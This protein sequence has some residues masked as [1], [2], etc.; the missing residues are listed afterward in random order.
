MS[1]ARLSPGVDKAAQAADKA[2][3]KAA[4]VLD[5]EKYYPLNKLTVKKALS[6]TALS[7]AILLSFPVV[8]AETQP[9]K[10]GKTAPA[11]TMAA[12]AK[13]AS[14]MPK[15]D[16]FDAVKAMGEELQAAMGVAE[17]NPSVYLD[18]IVDFHYTD[19]TQAKLDKVFGPAGG[20]TI[21][22]APADAGMLHYQIA[23][24]ANSYTE[25]SGPQLTWTDLS[26]DLMLNKAGTTMSSRGSWSQFTVAGKD[27]TMVMKDMTVSS[28]QTRMGENI[29]LGKVEAGIASITAG[30]VTLSSL[31][32]SGGASAKG[33]LITAGYDGRIKTIEA[34]GKQVDDLHIAARLTN[35][36]AKTMEKFSRDFNGGMK[37]LSPE[38]K[39][40]AMKPI[41]KA[42]GKS[43]A[44]NGSAF[45]I[46]D[47]SLGFLANRASI[48]GKVSMGKTTD[49]DFSNFDAFGKK[50]IVRLNVR[51]PVAMVTDV[52][53]A[54]LAQDA[55][56]KHQTMSDEALAQGAQS[57]TDMVVGKLLTSNM[58]KLENGVIL[59]LIEFKTG[60]LYFNGKEVPLPTSSNANKA[61]VARPAAPAAAPLPAPVPPGKE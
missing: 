9:I 42:L 12:P 51:V 8:A 24:P 46:D 34:M 53:K 23:L 31:S 43:M 21:K 40:A 33:K 22:H 25:A 47:L 37:N 54:F 59:S 17:G 39:L 55:A 32:F 49:A 48:K 57:V 27:M 18:K 38:Q 61:P 6:L 52:S 2:G 16:L 7:A 20:L 36:D 30:P 60:K 45:E 5:N 19:A 3:D 26:A 41:F 28:N 10:S 1:S 56:S 4:N 58:A 15:S 13:A 50:L 29:W 11:P 35:I 44:A 14:P